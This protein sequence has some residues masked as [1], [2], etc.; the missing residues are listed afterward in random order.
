MSECSANSMFLLRSVKH[1]FLLDQ[2]DF[3]AQ[4][5]DLAHLELQEKISDID[6]TRLQC[7]LE[8][9]LRSF[10]ATADHYKDDVKLKLFTCDLE[11]LMLRIVC[12]DAQ[13]RKGM[14]LLSSSLL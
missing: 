7:L 5:M 13:G 9:A 1:Y 4:F 8:M 10:S 12:I 3:I 11:S 2:G 14:E 6:V